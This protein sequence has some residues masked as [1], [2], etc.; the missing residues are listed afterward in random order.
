MQD[1]NNDSTK[2]GSNGNKVSIGN[3]VMSYLRGDFLIAPFY[4]RQAKLMLLIV[5]LFIINISNRYSGQR[6]QIEIN[7]LKDT[8]VHVRYS[9]LV[10][11]SELS[12]E[13]RQ[14]YIE[15]Y[16]KKNKS[17]VKISSHSPYVIEE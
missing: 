7:M 13:N 3:T 4:R 8:L 15:R 14:S 9:S 5:F 16:L 17:E 1:N 6:E 12:T 11:L 10:R 2:K